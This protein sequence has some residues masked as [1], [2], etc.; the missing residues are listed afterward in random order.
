MPLPD[1]D[2]DRLALLDTATIATRFGIGRRTLRRWSRDGLFPPAIYLQAGAR[3]RWRRIDVE[4]WLDKQAGRQR[5]RRWRGAVA[6][7]LNAD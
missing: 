7:A 6:A 5:R 3:P 1:Q 2:D 4:L